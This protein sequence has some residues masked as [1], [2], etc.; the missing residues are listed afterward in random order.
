MKKEKISSLKHIYKTIHRM[1]PIRIRKAKLRNKKEYV[2]SSKE[3]ELK[4]S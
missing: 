3:R 2:E 4:F 1:Y